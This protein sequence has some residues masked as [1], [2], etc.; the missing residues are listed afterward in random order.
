MLSFSLLLRRLMRHAD[1][2]FDA[3]MLDDIATP[4][5]YYY[6]RYYCCCCYVDAIID[7]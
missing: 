6:C 4:R 2:I 1:V 5:R 3:D 7:A